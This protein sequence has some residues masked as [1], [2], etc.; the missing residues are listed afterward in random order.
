ML[1]WLLKAKELQ[2]GRLHI[3]TLMKKMGIKAIY[4]RSNTSTAVTGTIFIPLSC[5]SR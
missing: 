2:P 5:G 1:Q 3:A 4:R